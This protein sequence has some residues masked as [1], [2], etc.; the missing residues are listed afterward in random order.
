[1]R[2]A[3]FLSVTAVLVGVVPWLHAQDQKAEIQKRL[4]SQFALTQPTKDK[5]DIATAGAVLVL[6]K[7]GLLMYSVSNP[8][9][10]QSTY[11][12]GKITRNVFGKNFLR[13]FG[14]VMAT[15]GQSASDIVQRNF[16][17]GEK[18]WVTKTEVK[19]DGAVF[20]LFSDRFDEV[21]YYGELKFPFPKGQAPPADELMNTIAE[22]L[23]VEPADNSAGGE[24]QTQTSAQ[25]AEP[26]AP[27]PPPPTPADTPPAPPKTIALGQTKD[28]VVASFGQPQ[29]VATVGTKEID[30]YPDMKV[31]FVNGKVADV[32]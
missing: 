31:T 2:R 17:A 6:H 9:P 18:F 23:T 8:I 20:G 24:A 5:S 10:P 28:M 32:E 21:R 30:Y 12:K 29:K 15:P 11:K 26:P 1:M 13:D 16:A 27:I 25:S 4:A 14:N 22:V 7:N 3:V 19:D